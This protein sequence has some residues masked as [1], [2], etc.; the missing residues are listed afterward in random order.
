[1]RDYPLSA[2]QV[3]NSSGST[4]AQA[5]VAVYMAAIS[6]S[7]SITAFAESIGVKLK[8]ARALAYEWGVRFPDYDPY[9][10]PKRLEWRKIK[11]G[12]ELLDQG[13]VVGSCQR[14]DSGRYR[15]ELFSAAAVE[16]WDARRAMREL[17]AELD[18]MSNDL[19]NFNGA[20]VKTVETSEQGLVGEVIYPPQ[21]EEEVIHKKRSALDY[22]AM[23]REAA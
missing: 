13:E 12:W 14:T 5:Q 4:F 2:D 9:A 20:P 7:K 1:M 18:G 22:R 8:D 11:V 10:T 6:D 19:P 23:T 3:R 15:A 17:S 16:N 21:A